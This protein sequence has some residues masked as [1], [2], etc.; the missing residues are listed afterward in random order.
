MSVIGRFGCLSDDVAVDED[1]GQQVGAPI[2][3]KS[4]FG[5]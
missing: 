4:A 5:C 2:I 1:E 3:Y